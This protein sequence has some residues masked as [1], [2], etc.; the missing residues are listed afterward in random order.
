MF[1]GNYIIFSKPWN[2]VTEIQIDLHNEIWKI[3]LWICVY[4]SRLLDYNGFVNRSHYKAP[5]QYN[6]V[7]YVIVHTL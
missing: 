4:D 2:V 6:I 7:I 5:L 1:I 3:C